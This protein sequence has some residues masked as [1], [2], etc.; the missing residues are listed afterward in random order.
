MLQWTPHNACISAGCAEA[1]GGGSDQ[2]EQVQ[3]SDDRVRLV[4][5]GEDAHCVEIRPVWALCVCVC[6]CVS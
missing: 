5:E 4:H 6:G 3:R 2:P 1:H